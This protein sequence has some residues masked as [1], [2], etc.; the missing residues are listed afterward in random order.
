M[1]KA[2][3]ASAILFTLLST[4][5][6]AQSTQGPVKSI[7]GHGT[8]SCGKYT[9]ERKD[10]NSLFPMTAMIWVSGYLSRAAYVR[11][12]NMLKTVEYEALQG[13]MDNY[14]AA[15]PLENVATAASTLEVELAERSL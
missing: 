3:A 6:S 9:S 13:W 5:A 8:M 4:P 12:G 14:C 15:N 7:I 10:S 2:V 1:I 11:K